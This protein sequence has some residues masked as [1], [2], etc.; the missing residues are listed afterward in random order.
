[1]IQ[2]CVLAFRDILPPADIP[3]SEMTAS[4]CLDVIVDADKMKSF[5]DA[6]IA[7]ALTRFAELRPPTRGGMELADG[8]REEVSLELGISPQAAATQILQARSLVTRLPAT[9]TA[10]G[11]GHIDYRRALAMSDLTG[12][13]S[14]QDA[15]LVERRV[16]LKGR[17][18]NPG[19]FRD[20]VRHHVIKADPEAAAHRRDAAA[21]HR[22]VTYQPGFD[23]MGQLTADLTAEETYAA[24]KQLDRLAHRAKTP[25]DPRTIGQCRADVL[26]DLI[27]GK[28]ME[29]LNVAVHVTVPLTTLMGLN[30]HPGE[31]SGYGPITAEHA[32]DLA[33]NA[34]WRRVITDP[35]G[36]VLEVS[37]RR[38]ASPALV[39]H[40]RVRDRTCRVPGCTVLAE[41]AEIDHTVRHADHG[42]TSPHNTGAYCK[43]H[44][45]WKERSP[46]TVQQ[47]EPGTF[48]FTSPEGRTYTNPPDPY[49][50]PPY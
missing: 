47:P 10:L 40:V 41:N 42:E 46:W 8:A 37:R 25:G 29:H 34:T 19:K 30:R 28:N 33:R 7:Q 44:N 21:Q 31:L 14:D 49:D 24:Y 36:Q 48:T 27:L 23:G 50:Q 6:R 11:D 4:Q 39:D 2:E 9:L 3:V 45:L 5:Y 18:S 20:A 22:D 43:F 12:A 13:L 16:L 26:L 1:M 35:A 17:R 38:Y 32:R 15:R